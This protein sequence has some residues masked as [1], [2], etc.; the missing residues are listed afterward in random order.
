MH[1]K[2]F[3]KIVYIM[4]LY[5]NKTE[6]IDRYMLQS[7]GHDGSAIIAAATVEKE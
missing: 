2:I 3:H 7:Y 6:K 1:V 4:H 5:A